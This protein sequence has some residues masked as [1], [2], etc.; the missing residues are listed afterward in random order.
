MQPARSGTTRRRPRR[1]SLE[2]PVDTRLV[3]KVGLLLAGPLAIAALTIARPGPLPAPTL[4]SSFDGAVAVELTQELARN[5]PSR[6]PGSPAAEDAATWFGDKL[7]LYGLKV[8]EDAWTERVP[9]LGSVTLRNLQAVVKGA[10][11][12]PIVV[13]AHRDN[14]GGSAGAN[15]NASGTA[16]LVELARA[17]A[18]SGTGGAKPR[19]PLH[20]LVFLSTDGGAFG[21]LGA[22]RFAA[23]SPLRGRVAAVMS[24]DALAGRASPRIELAGLN[25][26]SPTPA[27]ARTVDARVTT[28]LGLAPIRPGVIAQL[29]SLG[30]PFGYGE[31]AP[32]LAAGMPAVRVGTARD[33][34]SPPGADELEGLDPARLTLLGAAVEATLGSLDSAVELPRSTAGALF[35]GPRAIRGWALQLLLLI[36]VA[37]FAAGAVDL[38]ARCRRRH[39]PLLP[40]LRALRRRLG[41]WL[42]VAGLVLLGA[43]LDVFPRDGGLPPPPDQPPVDAWPFLGLALLAAVGAAAW[44]RARI[45]LVP[46]EI[47]SAEE[48]LAAYAVTFVALL[49]VALATALVSP[50]TLVF[51]LPSLYAWLWLPQFRRVRGGASDLIYGVG[52]IGPVLALVVLGTELELGARAPLY[53]VALITNGTLPWPTTLVLAAWA[54]VAAQIAAIVAGRYAGLGAASRR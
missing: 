14:N 54:A 6:V 23:T 11:D 36:A 18:T 40:A 4:P 30:L 5:I 22:A 28:A 49:G 51:V 45:P 9:G 44:L 50:Y 52:L 46:Q 48:E 47:A 1:G 42:L 19:R 34:G 32:F 39:L 37:P 7:A 15:D 33:G 17:Y 24:L 35:L 13:V 29:V 31:Q 53:A 2:R 12:E 8:R 43:L 41:F 25:G 38:L 10:V 20:T 3:R 26:R 27:L 21:S 16:A